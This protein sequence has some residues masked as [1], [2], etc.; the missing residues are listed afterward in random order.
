MQEAEIAALE[1]EKVHAEEVIEQAQTAVATRDKALEEMKPLQSYLDAF[2][3]AL[4]GVLPFSPGKL[5]KMFIGLM[6]EYNIVMLKG[7]VTKYQPS[8]ME[9]I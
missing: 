7:I 9:R 5:K 2:H 8:K 1:D 6:I 4:S 3:E